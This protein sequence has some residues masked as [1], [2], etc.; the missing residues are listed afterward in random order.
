MATVKITNQLIQTT[1]KEAVAKGKSIWLWDSEVKGFGVRCLQNGRASYQAKRRLGEGGRKAKTVWHV[2][3]HSDKLPLGEAREQAKLH[4]LAI[5]EGKNLNTERRTTRKVQAFNSDNTLEAV[6]HEYLEKQKGNH[7]ARYWGEVRRIFKADIIPFFGPKLPVSD[8]TKRL[9]LNLIEGRSTLSSGRSIFATLRPFFK[10]ALRRE[11]IALNP[12]DG[13]QPPSP[14]VARDRVLSEEEVAV[15]WQAL[16]SKPQATK[17]Q[18]A[19]FS[20]PFGPFYKLL[21]LTAQRRDEV[22]GMRWE[23]LDLVRGEWVIPKERTKNSKSHL[24]HLSPQVIDILTSIPKTNS[25]YVFTTTGETHISGFSKAKANLDS[26]VLFKTPWRVHDLRRTAASGMAALGAQPFIIERILNHVSGS[27][28]GLV[29]VYQRH[30]YIDKRRDALSD[31][32]CAVEEASKNRL[33]KRFM[34]SD[35]G[36]VVA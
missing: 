4:L 3:G 14:P 23:E 6:S 2:F 35:I 17:E 12:M 7:S 32:A 29:G 15:L 22:A 10:W 33:H 8:I 31:W 9:V 20:Y 19:C 5:G 21:L 11:L 27:T 13:L 24:V 25:R 34:W 26:I 18:K 28:G 36:N 30:E 1:L 16:T